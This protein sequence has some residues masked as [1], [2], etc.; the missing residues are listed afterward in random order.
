[1]SDALGIVGA[2]ES[3]SVIADPKSVSDLGARVVIYL[4]RNASEA[5]EEKWVLRAEV[6]D[7]AWKGKWEEVI[8]QRV[9][10]SPLVVFAGL[11]SPAAVLTE[12]VRWIRNSLHNETHRAYV[13]DPSESSHFKAAL[14][15]PDEAHIE[16]GWCAFMACLANRLT[17]EQRAALAET[18]R[19]L[20]TENAWPDEV[21]GIDGLCHLFFERGLL[22]SG[23]QRAV[24]LLDDRKYL[25]DQ[26]QVR[27]LIGYLLLG[28]GLAQRRND[29]S[30]N[31]RHD[32][33]VEM[34]RDG[35]VV[36]SCLPVSAEGTKHWAAMEPKIRLALTGFTS[37]ERP[38]TVLLGSLQG[39]LPD[40]VT[41][42][43]DIVF[44]DDAENIVAPLNGP[45]YVSVDALRTDVTLADRMVA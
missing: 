3:V 39:T 2:G 12:S 11:G 24:W 17:V 8:A 20:C 9:L 16:M 35:H 15:L 38:S 10:T 42:P 43:L 32:G 34:R 44:D 26:E 6:I 29:V 28:L 37:Y 25:S 14:A 4:H 36:A 13:V 19:D 33:V 18:C 22:G 40:D 27:G 31:V 45:M 30:L 41:P 23:R 7:E 1:M 5:D 21:V